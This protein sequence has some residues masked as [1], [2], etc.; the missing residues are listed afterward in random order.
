MTP[1]LFL[2]GFLAAQGRIRELSQEE[3]RFSYHGIKVASIKIR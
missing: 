1:G 3:H 2:G